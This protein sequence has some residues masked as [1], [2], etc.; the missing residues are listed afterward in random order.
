M[1]AAAAASP[2]PA[3]SSAAAVF[4]VNGERV[5]L[6]EGDV[7]PG[8][9]LLEFLRTR[10]RF[11]G[12]KLG[13][14]EGGCGACVVLLSTYDAASGAVSHA[15]AS[16]CLTLLHGLHH[17]AVTTT[18]GL[19]RGR[20]RAGLHAVHER[21]AGFH[22]TQC[23]FCTPGVCMSLAAA[24]AGAEA[25]GVGR[26]APPEGSARLTAAEAE[27]AV[28]GN[29]CRCTGYR[30]IA[31]ACK[32][33]AADVDLEDLGLNTFWRKGDAHASKLPRY[34]EGAIGV[35]PEFLK[36]EI[37]ASSGIGGCT[38]ALVE[39]GS[40]WHRPRSVEEYYNMVGSELFGKSRTKVI[41][42][43]TAS[44]VYRE[45]EVYD[46]YIDLRCI[47]E[48][49]SVS[50]EAKGIEIGAAVSIS[51]AIEA[52]REAGGCNDVIFCKIAD[53][54]EKV[55]SPFVRNTASLGGN[56]IMAQRDQ[57]AS[58]MATILLAAGSS[59]CIQ[60]SSKRLTVTLEE[61][62]Q[63]PPCD[64]KTL[65]LSIYIPH[66]TP[67][68][69]LSDDRTMDKAVSTRG[70]SVL[71]ETYRASPRPLGNAVAYLNAA[72]LAQVSSDGTSSSLILR[73]LCL[74]F[75]AYG[76]QHA[77]RA[78]NVEKLLV[79]KPITA[80]VL[81]EACT[82]L[83][84]TIV[85]KEG[86]RHAAYRSSLAVAFLFS[87]LYPVNKDTLKPVKAVHLNCSVPSGTNGNPNC[88]PDA[89]VDASL[90]INNMKS[91]SYSNDRI[92]EYSNQII[93]INKD[94]LP[95]GIPAKKVGAELQ[96]SGEAVFVD[97]IPSPKDCLYGAFVYSTK[98]LAYVRSIELDP[99]LKQLN[100]LG[101]VTVKDIPESGGNVGA[102]TIFGP[103]PLFGDPV[104]QCAGEPLAIVIAE[105]QR[106]ANIAA[107]RAVVDYSTENLDAPILS[108]EDAVR[109][110]SYFET[111][112]FL[113]PQKIGDF[114][115]GMA[116]ADQKIY[117]AEVKLN[118]Q[119]YFYMETQTALAIPDEDNCM[120]VYSSSQCP[121]TTQN[122]IA[123]CLGLPF[124]NVRVITR[125]VGGGFGGKA[126]RSLPVATA[127]A[128][129]AFKLRR[130][131]R[132][133][134][135]RKTDMIVSG[136]R[137][138]MKI[139]YS[140]GFKSDGKITA[141]H[142]DLFINAGMTKDVSL[143]IPHN[144]IEA[145]KKYNWGAFSYEAKVCKT[146]T[147]TKSAMRGP[148]EVQGSYVAEAIVEH[149]ASAL[150]TDANLVR[151]RNL[152]TVESLSLFHSECSEDGMGYTL[153]SICGQLT[154]S[155]NYQH[156]LEI[157][158]SFNRNNRWK[159]RGLAFVPIVHKV[160]SRPT[161]GKVS[162]LND[163]SIAVEVGG[164]ELGQGLWTK[165]KQ[166]AAFGL[167]QLWTDGSQEFF[168]RIRII[169]ADTLSNVQGG[170]TTGSTTSESSCEAVRL[171]CN[172]LVDRLKP[173]KE[174]FQEKQ[175]SLSWDE[176]ISKAKMVGVD[177]SA[178]EYY[179]PGASGSYLNYGAAAS[180]VE[181]DLLT[182]ATT[183]L[184]SD[185]IYDCG[186]SLNPAVD[187]GQVEG[188]FVQGIGYFMSEEYVTNS[189][190]LVISDGTWT[191]KIPTVDTIPKQFNVKLINS[192]FH[193]KRVLS[194][195]A[196]G[197]PPLLLAASVH[198]ATREAIRAARKQTR[199]SDSVPSS[200]SHFDLEVPAIMPVVKELCGLDN[201][202]R[203]LE[204]LLSS[205]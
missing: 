106:F 152:H 40:T 50:K 134:L 59:V 121:E 78:S 177:L 199:F 34:D 130:P 160:L 191:Y 4:A 101:V 84:K 90:K 119:Y 187:L 122:V 120:V 169:Q 136:G 89:H 86:T 27:R 21:L 83:K 39:S 173:V 171:A 148:G 104:T 48:L 131:V 170:W 109:R 188:A 194:S 14:G 71:F 183:I 200:P 13:C 46:R 43:N 26:P 61:F 28:A 81:L 20:G 146:N 56:L 186:Q 144:F 158:Q 37:R 88:G 63:M 179:I 44:G 145:L 127:C 3:P 94:Y 92:L 189:D 110:C 25:K 68:G 97:D 93:E 1:A 181:I 182:G 205:K 8:A 79:G 128:L 172:I 123:K 47:R 126:V 125:R 167:G 150:S 80:S 51:K 118:S 17:R 62:L 132:M 116:E 49:N 105:T 201:V 32:S 202:E 166:M 111:P 133:Y 19:G 197:E 33:F 60:V 174:Q 162:I 70:T 112:P 102:S 75:G 198:C 154:A 175:S 180:E 159:K 36:A 135:D 168:D 95:V 45:A 15:A 96:A 147:A 85:P 73:E 108:I 163:G 153:P 87:F 190:G 99:S 113:L 155:E 54:M 53:H 141:L 107:K 149:V 74:A 137:H 57:F 52:L 64:Y 42:G 5:E 30:P 204:S 31:D 67:A 176:L 23:G 7:D 114:S 192:G 161:P 12:P 22:A 41:V 38:P 195:K 2:A 139:C 66:W 18:E 58:D 117:S 184:R 29:L 151:H 10:T 157:V 124:H 185:L 35:F 143:I 98:P 6:R 164:I 11:T 55:A 72:F 178:R 69:A 103:E 82:L 16:S 140:V 91:G 9:T 77:I 100:T 165:V 196:S 129:A 193:K 65:L 138:P 76:T 156:H 24:L 115:K 203:Y 142:I